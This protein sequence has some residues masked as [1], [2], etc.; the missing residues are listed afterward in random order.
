MLAIMPTLPTLCDCEK[1]DSL[2]RDKITDVHRASNEGNQ[3]ILEFVTKDGGISD[4]V[5]LDH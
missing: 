3:W 5:H 4:M 2:S 1:H